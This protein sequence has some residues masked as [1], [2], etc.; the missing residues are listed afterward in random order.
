MPYKHPRSIELVIA[1]VLGWISW[2]SVETAAML[3]C[4]ESLDVAEPRDAPF[5]MA[6]L[7]SSGITRGEPRSVPRSA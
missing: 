2:K 5:V 1:I 6:S 3:N 4:S 7:V